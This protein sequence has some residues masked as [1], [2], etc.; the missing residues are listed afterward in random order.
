VGRKKSSEG[1]VEE[2]KEAFEAAWVEDRENREDAFSDLRFLAGNQWPD[3]VRQ[4]RQAQNRPCLTINR[5]PQFVHQIANNVRANPPSL[6]AIP[7][8]G[9]ATPELANIFSGLFRQIQKNSNATVVFSQAVFNSVACGIGHFRI[10]TDYMNDSCF[11]QEIFIKHI[12]H[13]LS[14]FWDP[15]AAEI[16]RADAD[17]CV[18]CDLI[19]RKAFEKRFPD[20]AVADFNAPAGE[21]ET[22]LFWASRD[23]VRV[24]EYWRKKFKKRTIARL[25]T[26]ETVDVSDLDHN[27]LAQL[28]VLVT[29]SVNSFEIEQWLVSG[30][31][32]LQG[33]NPWAGRYIPIFPVIGTE[34]ALETKVVRNGLIRFAKDAQQLYNF[35]RSAAAES[36]AL[37]PRAPFLATPTMIAKFKG[38]WDTQN[39][40][41]RPYLLY[42]PDPDA[43]GGRP[44]RE[45][46]PEVPAAFAE[47]ARTASDEMKAATGVYD[48]A[49][50]ARS[51]EISG[52]AIKA[53]ES[54][55]DNASLHYQDNLIAT[56]HHLGAA[57]IDLIPKVYDADRV[58][59]V[60]NDQDEAHPV[61]I[62]VTVPGPH[63]Q[64]VRL[65]DL[66]VG[67]YQLGVKMGPSY[68]TARQEL[69]SSLLELAQTIPAAGQVIADIAVENMDFP[70][71]E[72]AAKRLN[73]LLPPGLSGEPPSPQQ[74]QAQQQEQQFKV[75]MAQAAL[76]EAQGKA[77]KLH[78]EAVRT[79]AEA[80]QLAQ[81]DP[82]A[83]QAAQPGFLDP[84]GRT[85]EQVQGERMKN[86]LLAMQLQQ[87]RAKTTDAFL[88][89]QG[90]QLDNARKVQALTTPRTE[91]IP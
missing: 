44:M 55:G 5:L 75:Q 9:G 49:L 68:T 36:I 35:N 61:R 33:P 79:A 37:A 45:A 48:A 11:D 67:D 30:E 81:G 89:A 3:D 38:Q 19:P 57:L 74:I 63:G 25:E 14:V 91:K 52:I 54:Q 72:A 82:S 51:N 71:A 31:E 10:V 7:T 62:N 70:G 8:G 86:A 22:G 83:Q 29:R 27:S 40:I 66:S 77:V 64:P 21:A 20:A 78:A 84:A 39:T 90:R 85:P 2:A 69:V 50:G 28:P 18:V 60:V 24:A 1:I 47:E 16:T 15:K 73:A 58:V 46:P 17:Y 87:G 34:V 59:A 65:N 88:L 80:R 6:K 42:E 23:S 32:V 4:L 76:A 12:R 56:L 53:R 43:P 26:G 13:P 41:A